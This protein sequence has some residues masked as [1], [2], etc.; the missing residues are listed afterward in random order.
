M[1][2]ARIPEP[3]GMKVQQLF[4]DMTN[5]IE[6]LNKEISEL[7]LMREAFQQHEVAFDQEDIQSIEKVIHQYQQQLK[8]LEQELLQKKHIYQDTIVSLEETLEVR[9]SVLE[10]MD[11]KSQILAKHPDLMQFFVRKQANLTHV[12]EKTKTQLFKLQS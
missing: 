5:E 11:N 4:C 10:Q 1:D 3:V 6:G 9:Q 7:T 8:T 2:T 12:L